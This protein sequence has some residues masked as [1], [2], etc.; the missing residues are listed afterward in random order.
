MTCDCWHAC[1]RVGWGNRLHPEAFS[2]PAKIAYSLA[3]RIYAHVLEEHWV[4]A[5]DSV[6]DCFGGIAGTALHASLAG[7]HWSGVELEERFVGLAQ[8]NI[9]RWQSRYSRMPRW[10]TPTIRQ[11][12]SREL[13]KVLGETGGLAKRADCY[14]SEK[15]IGTRAMQEGCYGTSP[16][17]LGSMKAGDLV[18]SSP[19][20]CGCEHTKA[21]A[22][23]AATARQL[24]RAGNDDGGYNSTGNV[25]GMNNTSDFWSAARTIVEQTYLCLRPQAHAIWIVKSFVRGGKIV[26]FPGQWRALCESVGFETLHEH[27]ALL[28]E[29][30]GSQATTD[31]EI[32][33]KTIARKSFFRRLHEKKNPG[34]EID[35]E[36]VYCMVRA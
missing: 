22:G 1:Y 15:N 29:H 11:G 8:A 20:Y 9:N 33:H 18:V 6:I 5:G 32:E 23:I 2:H 25:S 21:S 10:V 3:E 28:T 16:G 30:K 35:F 31:G 36:T 4:E 17:Q 34:T 13:L 7:L 26:D 24:R 12:D 19:G 14:S 27:H